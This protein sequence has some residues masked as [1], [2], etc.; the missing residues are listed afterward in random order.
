MKVCVSIRLKI[1]SSLVNDSF[2]DLLFLDWLVF[3][4]DLKLA[5]PLLY[6]SSC[7]YS[8]S[9]YSLSSKETESC[10]LRSSELLPSVWS[11]IGD[12]FKSSSEKWKLS[13][14][15]FFKYFS[16][17]TFLL[18]WLS[19]LIAFFLLLGDTCRVE[20]EQECELLSFGLQLIWLG[21]YPSCSL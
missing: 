12:S 19:L 8:N 5:L 3:I 20:C 4:N 15:F 2:V 10:E 9:F 13:S 21:N 7:W 14:V 1:P 17:I 6:L 18:F 16:G 11:L